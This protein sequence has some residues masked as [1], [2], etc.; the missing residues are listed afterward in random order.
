MGVEQDQGKVV[1]SCFQVLLGGI[2]TNQLMY[3]VSVLTPLG[4]DII[5]F[6]PKSD[7]PLLYPV[8]LRVSVICA[9]DK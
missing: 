3:S 1:R 8:E 4:G 9:D 5:A 2:Y 7:A 6:M